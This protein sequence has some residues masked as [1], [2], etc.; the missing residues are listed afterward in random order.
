MRKNYTW[1]VFQNM[2]PKYRVFVHHFFSVLTRFCFLFCFFGSPN[3]FKIQSTLK[4]HFRSFSI[5]LMLTMQNISKT[6]EKYERKKKKAQKRQIEINGERKSGICVTYFKKFHGNFALFCLKPKKF[7][8]F[9]IET[10]HF[11]LNLKLST[12]Y[13]GQ[14]K[15]ESW[16]CRQFSAI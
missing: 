14:L 1:E 11:A 6:F 2:S 9:T 12:S 3:H 7:R 8:F 5:Q 16:D 15:P 13:S 4:K 10:R